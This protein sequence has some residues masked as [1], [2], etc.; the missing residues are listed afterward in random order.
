K[1]GTSLQGALSL[2][3]RNIDVA[4][5]YAIIADTG[6]LRM[7]WGGVPLRV[8]PNSLT[9]FRDGQ[10]AIRV[11]TNSYW[12]VTKPIIDAS[13]QTVA[14]V[15]IPKDVFLEQ[16]ALWFQDLFNLWVIAAAGLTTSV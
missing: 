10:S 16:R 13:N 14:K 15:I 9:R 2:R 6:E 8:D 12:M 5:D 4:V 7:A 3:S 11:G 1:F